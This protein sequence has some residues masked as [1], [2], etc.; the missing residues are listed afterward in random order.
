[1]MNEDR[2]K[3]LESKI[4]K[5]KIDAI[6]NVK[7]YSYSPMQS[8]PSSMLNNVNTDTKYLQTKLDQ[9]TSSKKRLKEHADRMNGSFQNMGVSNVLNNNSKAAQRQSA[10]N[11]GHNYGVISASDLYKLRTPTESII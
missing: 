11:G 4:R 3:S 10:A 7:E 5:H 2:L 6:R 1:M 8:K 9:F